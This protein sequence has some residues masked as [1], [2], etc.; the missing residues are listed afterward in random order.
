MNS[1]SSDPQIYLAVCGKFHAFSLAREYSRM[2]RLAGLYAVDQRLKPPP[3]VASD[4]F[5]NRWDLKLWRVAGRYAPAVAAH[6]LA[7]EYAIFDRWIDRRFDKLPGG[8]FH[9]WNTHVSRTLKHLDPSRWL[10]CV[11]R[12]CPHNLF[13]HQLLQEESARLD[14]PYSADAEALAVAVQELYDADI[15]VAPSQYS[16][17]SYEDPVLRA[18]LRVNPLGANYSYRERTPSEGRPLRL[19]LV[20]NAFLRKGTHYLIEAF[21][22]IDDP[23]AELWIRGEVPIEYRRRIT[24]PRISLI[25]AVSFEKLQQLYRDATLFCL[26]SVDE[27]FGMVALEALSYGLPVIYTDHCGV[28]DVLTPSVG[29]RVPIRSPEAIASAV[30]T[31]ADWQREDFDRFDRDRAAVLASTTWRHCAERMMSGVY[32]RAQPS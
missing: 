17:G 12:S 5:H 13:Q 19:L 7:R 8:V 30:R 26:P 15:I 2:G 1:V 28:A 25:P 18:K 11:E 14:L 22:R 10:R 16:A 31:I 32:R 6:S 20:G 27:G 24:D 21:S 23:K 4:R 9:G 3:G 29:V